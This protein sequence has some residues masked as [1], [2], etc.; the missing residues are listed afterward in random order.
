LSELHIT[1]PERVFTEPVKLKQKTIV[2]PERELTSNVKLIQ[3]SVTL[4]DRGLTPGIKF[5]EKTIALNE[6]ILTEPIKFHGHEY[7]K[8]GTIIIN[9]TPD[10]LA[11]SGWTLAGPQDET[12]SGDITLTEMPVG[13]YTLIWDD[14]SGYTTPTSAPQTLTGV[15]TITF[16]GEYTSACPT[17]FVF[18]NVLPTLDENPLSHSWTLRATW[19]CDYDKTETQVAYKKD[20]GEWQYTTWQA[21]SPP[22]TSFLRVMTNS[23]NLLLLLGYYNFYVSNRD[24]CGNEESSSEYCFILAKNPVSGEFEINPDFG[25]TDIVPTIFSAVVEGR[26][27]WYPRFSWSTGYD[28]EEKRVIWGVVGG[29]TDTESWLATSGTAHIYDGTR[30]L[31]NGD[32]HYWVQNVNACGDEAGSVEHFFTF[33]YNPRTGEAR[34]I[35]IS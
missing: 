27:F 25:F 26:T 21:E 14:V 9:Q 7:T 5:Q 6:R 11:D 29:A 4:P 32:Y 18:S 20:G 34:I 31:N 33:Y 22:A 35:N 17:P 10:I 1:I 15:G 28:M 16:V 19:D 13:D 3:K 12:G 8:F 24:A 2:L 23:F 30:A